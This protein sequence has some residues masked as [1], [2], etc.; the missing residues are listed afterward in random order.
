M[1]SSPTQQPII[2]SATKHF[3]RFPYANEAPQYANEL[4]LV[5]NYLFDLHEGDM[6]VGPTGARQQVVR[7]RA[8]G[9]RRRRRFGRRLLRRRR[10]LGLG[11]LGAVTAVQQ[12]DGHFADST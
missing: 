7:G 2:S 6:C 5:N 12:S 9:G 11:R 4:G 1:S 8:I 3:L 10:R